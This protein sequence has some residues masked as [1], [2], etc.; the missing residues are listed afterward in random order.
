[1]TDTPERA[2]TSARA[3]GTAA[4][5]TGN[6][7]GNARIALVTGG[8]SGLGLAMARQLCEAGF[9]PVVLARG[10]ERLKAAELT[11]QNQESRALALKCD[12]TCPEE[13]EDAA[14]EIRRR[15]G[16]IHYLVLN[17]GVVHVGLLEDASDLSS[18]KADIETDLWG[19]L[20]SAHFFVPLLSEGGR[21]LVISSGF[22]LMGAAGYGPYCAA[23]AGVINLAASLRRELLHRRIS[24][25][26]ACPGDVDTPQYRE[27]LASMPPW[28]GGGSGRD[29]PLT[30]E[31][32]AS[33]IL[34]KAT[35]NR[36]LVVISW[37]LRW[38]LF[39]RRILPQGWTEALLDRLFPRP[40]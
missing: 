8:S 26:V 1:M 32:A 22:G 23:K 27:E 5:A 36:F 11:L 3:E 37:D 34:R 38:L 4:P 39:I 12:I 16:N 2:E 13:L 18:L 35:G 31:V 7:A 30:P 25:H 15:F 28:M 6:I 19:T 10:E 29:K 14:E 17:A 24:V 21:L 33:R 9:V 40:R 20:L